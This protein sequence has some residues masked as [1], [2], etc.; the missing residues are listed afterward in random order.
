MTDDPLPSSTWQEETEAFNRFMRALRKEDTDALRELLTEA[1][2]FFPETDSAGLA[3]LS[4]HIVCMEM[5]LAR[6]LKLF[7][8]ALQENIPSL[9]WYKPRRIGSGMYEDLTKPPDPS[10]YS[11]FDDPT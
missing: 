2:Q 11:D 6:R 7:R 4:Q 9:S 3:P 8:Q 5:A 10:T 1:R